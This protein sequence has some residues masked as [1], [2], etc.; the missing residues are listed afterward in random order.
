MPVG[1]LLLMNYLA[2]LEFVAELGLPLA[3]VPC[4]IFSQQF[5]ARRMR[6]S[7]LPPTTF[8]QFCAYLAEKSDAI[9]TE[10]LP[11][12]GKNL[13]LFTPPT[14]EEED[15]SSLPISVANLGPDLGLL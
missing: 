7:G 2:T 3:V 9:R 8:Q 14:L 15:K 13:V 4:C 6:S 12:V 5:P 10:H 11:F 1:D